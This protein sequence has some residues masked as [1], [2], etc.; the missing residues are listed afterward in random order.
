IID[1]VN[2]LNATK[3]S[4]KNKN[5]KWID[6]GIAAE[7]ICL[8]ATELGLGSCMIGWFNEKKLKKILHIPR[9]KSIP[10]LVTL[11]YPDDHYRQK[12]RKSLN[13]ICVFNSYK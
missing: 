4:I 9:N 10:L 12:I 8:Q 11:G 2:I 13:E 1:E 6:I 5:Y 7:N 3:I